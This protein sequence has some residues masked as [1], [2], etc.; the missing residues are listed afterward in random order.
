MLVLMVTRAKLLQYWSTRMWWHNSCASAL[1]FIC[2]KFLGSKFVSVWQQLLP[3]SP[4][5]DWNSS[6]LLAFIKTEFV[7]YREQTLF[8]L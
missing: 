4:F 1:V 5:K 2:K 7:P 3:Y 6:Q 8:P